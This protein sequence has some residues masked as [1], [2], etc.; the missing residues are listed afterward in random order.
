MTMIMMGYFS[1]ILRTITSML[2]L[3]IIILIM[4]FDSALIQIITSSKIAEF[5]TIL[6]G[7]KLSFPQTTTLFIITAS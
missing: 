6:M 5:T 2:A 3:F 7:S 1:T 4:A